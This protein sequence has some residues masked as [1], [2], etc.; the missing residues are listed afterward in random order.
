MVLKISV[1]MSPRSRIL[2]LLKI[3]LL[4]LGFI[5]FSV[6]SSVSQAQWGK[7]STENSDFRQYPGGRDEEDL[8]VLTELPESRLKVTE[9]VLQSQVINEKAKSSSSTNKTS[10]SV[11]GE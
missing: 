10:P 8:R 5:G 11:R 1:I 9:Q 6:F 3:Y 2:T 7:S 4:G